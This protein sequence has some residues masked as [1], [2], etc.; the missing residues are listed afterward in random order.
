MINDA[1][2][3]GEYAQS[4]SPLDEAQ[5]RQLR[6]VENRVEEL[7]EVLEEM[8]EDPSLAHRANWVEVISAFDQVEYYLEVLLVSEDPLGDLMIAARRLEPVVLEEGQGP[9]S[10]VVD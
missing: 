3:R 8:L 4:T 10:R 6:V 5:H 9:E 2:R 7:G 1:D